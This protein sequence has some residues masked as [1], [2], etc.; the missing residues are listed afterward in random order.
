MTYEQAA[1]FRWNP[2]DAT[3]KWPEDEY[4]LQPVGRLTLDRNP[5]NFFEDV[6]QAA[7]APSRMIPGIEASPDKMLQGKINH[8]VV[9]LFLFYFG[10]LDFNH[11]ITILITI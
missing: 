7:F 8:I 4:P 2:F 9:L 3:K 11:A 5:S 6:E 10:I 1:K